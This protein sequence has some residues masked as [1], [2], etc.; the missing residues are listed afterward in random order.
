M[1]H[2]TLRKINFRTNIT[3]YFTKYIKKKLSWPITS[4]EQQWHIYKVAVMH[5]RYHS[6]I[7]KYYA[8]P[9]VFSAYMRLY[10]Y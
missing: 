7:S 3:Q 9:R 1:E 5:M 4:T 8:L 10:H 2:R 6:Q